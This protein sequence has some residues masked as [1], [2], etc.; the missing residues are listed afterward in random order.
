M[1]LRSLWVGATRVLIDVAPLSRFMHGL[2]FFVLGMAILFNAPRASRLEIARRSPFLAV[3]AACEATVAWEGILAAAFSVSYLLP[4]LLQTVLLGLGY[5]ALLAFGLLVPIPP[6]PQSRARLSFPLAFVAFWLAGMLFAVAGPMPAG[7]IA[8]WWEIAARYGLAFPGGVLALWGLRRQNYRSTD[9]RMVRLVEGSRRMAGGAMGAF[10]LLAGVA[11]PSIAL[12]GGGPAGSRLQSGLLSLLSVLLAVCGV[13][14]AYGLT[15]MLSVIQRE[16]ERWIEGVEQSQALATDRE[17]IG[18]EL[19]DGIIQSIYAAG[20]MLE[21]ARQLIPEDA[22]SAETQL[23][24]A[25][26]SLNQTIQDIRRYIFNL[27]GEETEA[28]LVSGLEA[29]LRD[30][31]INTLLETE[32]IVEGEEPR[33]FGV[34]QRQHILQI[35]RE[36]LSNVARHARARSVEVRLRYGPDVLQLQIA[37]DGVGLPRNPTT[38]GQGLHNM[39]ER[40][41]LLGGT[42]DID[43]TPGK[44]VTLT[45]IAPYSKG[46]AS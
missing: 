38:K 40:A 37:D 19:H 12:L 17:R 24:R 1:D 34:E 9:A 27:R 32:L 15:Q 13:L 36:G 23:S 29:I 8:F 22:D 41:H 16:M 4:P 45:L 11:A 31:R 28:D 10:G 46:G 3:L 25:M 39:W 5:G 35:V 26:V 6:G 42:L 44:G 33:L 18:R 7:Q 43:S 2:A 14:L 21:G 20:L 30:F